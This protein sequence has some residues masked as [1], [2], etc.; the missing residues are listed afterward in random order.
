M[1]D[2]RYVALVDQLVTLDAEIPEVEFKVNNC[3]P[4]KIA[5]LV[6]AI[7]NSARLND[8]PCGYIAW[9]VEDGSHE[10][11]GTT[12]RPAKEKASSQP[13]ELWSANVI[14]PSLHISFPR[15][16]TS[17]G[18]H[19]ITRNSG[20]QPNPHQIQKY[21]LHQGWIRNAKT[22]GSSRV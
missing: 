9:G 14:S 7:S 18:P 17:Q 5:I 6:S 1:S 3:D 20:G 19:S 10:I 12:F 22:C 4:D 8:R 21:Q 13:L 11:K 2:D 15:G 16:R